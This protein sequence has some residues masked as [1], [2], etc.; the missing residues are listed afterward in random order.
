VLPSVLSG[1][2]FTWASAGNMVTFHWTKQRGLN[3]WPTET[4][5]RSTSPLEAFITI[6]STWMWEDFLLE[7]PL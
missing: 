7:H 6:V 4:L 1:S 5:T 3:H 2:S